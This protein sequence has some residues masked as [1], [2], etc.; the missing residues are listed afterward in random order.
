M[1]S[2]TSKIGSMKQDVERAA[3]AV[4]LGERSLK[5]ARQQAAE[6]R[7]LYNPLNHPKVLAL[8][9]GKGK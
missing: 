8:L 5:I 2:V 9:G 1:H 3:E 7:K 4:T 6:A